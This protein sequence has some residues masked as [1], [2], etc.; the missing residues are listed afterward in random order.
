MAREGRERKNKHSKKFI[1]EY[2][3]AEV[4][5]PACFVCPDDKDFEKLK[6]TFDR[7]YGLFIINHAPV[8]YSINEYLDELELEFR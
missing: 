2:N 5:I 6:V 8:Y 1:E 7:E 3:L 4:G